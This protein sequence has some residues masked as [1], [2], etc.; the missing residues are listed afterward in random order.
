MYE[1]TTYV[2]ATEVPES[3]DGNDV[4]WLVEEFSVIDEEAVLTRKTLQRSKVEK[5]AIKK[6]F[7]LI[8]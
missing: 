5:D 1:V 3:G 2:R 8:S 4:A 6:H 7:L